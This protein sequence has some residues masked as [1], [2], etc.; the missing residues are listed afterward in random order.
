[1]NLKQLCTLFLASCTLGVSAQNIVSTTPTNKNVILE[2]LT[3]IN[4]TFCPDGHLLAKQLKNNNPGRVVLLNVHAGGFA[5]TT[6]DLRTSWG[7]YLDGLFPVSGYPT[8]SVNRRMMPDGTQQNPNQTNVMT[9]RGYWAS[10][11]ATVLGEASPVNVGGNATIDIDTRALTLDVEAYYTAAGPGTSNKFHAIITQNNVPGPQAGAFRNPTAILPNGDYNHQH[12][13]RHSLTPNVGDDISTI[14]AMSLY[15]N[16]YTYTI[17]PSINNIAINMADLEIAVYVSEGPA[18]GAILSGDEA[19]ITF[20]TNTPL[21]VAN[22]TATFD[23]A[24]GSVCG[25][26]VD[27]T[28]RVTNMGSNPLTSATFEYVVNGGSPSTYTHTFATPLTTADYEDVTIPGISNLTPNGATSTVDLSITMLNGVA[29]PGTNTSN[30]LTIA[31]ASAQSASSTTVDFTLTTDNYGSET[32]WEL[33]DETTGSTVISGGGYSDVTGGQTFNA[34]GTLID[35][36]CYRFQI[37]DAYGD[38]ICC[39]YGNG[40]FALTAGGT[41]LA[42][43]GSFNTIDGLRFTFDFVTGLNPVP[44]NKA[45][46]I[47]I[48]PNPVQSNMTLE[49][50]VAETSDLNISIVNALGQQVQ[51]VVTGTYVGTTVLDVNTSDLSAGVYFLNITSATGSSTKRFIVEQ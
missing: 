43:G 38:G 37:T 6:P 45:A 2:E 17:P 25:T 31:T 39:Q 8:G 35:G 42:S 29:N 7:N 23:A 15:T 13:V 16:T 26:T 9:S 40:S 4:C 50:I 10:N 28:M 27:A 36:H 21:G 51:Q 12:A 46:D 30:G 44:V 3:G 33:V 11:A 18:T 47:N 1:M 5:N 34:S 19:N 41:T 48:M 20:N 24:F 14:A 49:F 32:N 22:N